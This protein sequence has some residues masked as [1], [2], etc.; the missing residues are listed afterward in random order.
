M[1]EKNFLE[2]HI[3]NMDEAKFYMVRGLNTLWFIFSDLPDEDVEMFV[4][5]DERIERCSLSDVM[6]VRYGS[7]PI[8]I[9]CHKDE[10][11]RTMISARRSE[12]IAAGMF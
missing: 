6:S 7:Q 8:Y 9:P 12:F 2:L 4:D 1:K 5:K 10:T 11:C 3:K